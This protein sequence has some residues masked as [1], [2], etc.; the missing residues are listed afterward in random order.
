MK[1]EI[2]VNGNN[3]IKNKNYYLKKY[4]N[5]LDVAPRTTETYQNGLKMFFEYLYTNDIQNPSREDIIAFRESIKLNHTS[6]TVN[7]YMI[8]IR[9]F[10]KWLSYEDMYKNISENIKGVTN[11]KEHKKLPLTIEQARLVLDNAINMRERMIFL[12]TISLGLRANELANI[13]LSDFKNKN[14][15]ICLYVLGKARSGKDDFV[16]INENLYKEIRIYI[17]KYEIKDYLFTSIRNSYGEK[18]TT[19]TLRL[20]V[21][22]MYKRVG[23]CGDEY[24]LHSL[25]HSF[26][27]FNILNG[28]DIR[29]VSQ[30]LRHKNLQTTQIYLHDLDKINNKC[31]NIAN[32]FAMKGM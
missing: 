17:E 6:S 32:E 8:A 7:T 19:K 15:T 11:N 3:F 4:F 10:F 14:G 29:E 26:A 28:L 18:L 12:M 31:F 25:R 20:I 1:K 24:S 27:T 21:K 13:R 22:N 9:S 5:Y 30:G 23:I 16:V 2:I